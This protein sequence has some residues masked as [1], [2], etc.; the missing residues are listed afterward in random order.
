MSKPVL[1]FIVGPTASG[2]T[3][4]SID[5][6]RRMNAEI[7]S[8]DS[9]QV[10]RR[11]DIGSAKPTMEEMRGVVHHL[12]GVIEPT[13]RDFSVAKYREAAIDA[14]NDI[15]SRGKNAIVVGGTGLYVNSLMYPLEFNAPPDEAKRAYWMERESE[16]KGSALSHLRELDPARANALHPNDVK[17]II[18]AIEVSEAMGAPMSELGRGFTARD[19]DALPYEIK[20]AA[21]DMPREELYNRIDARVDAMLEAGFLGEVES[22]LESGITPELPAMQGLGYKQL[23]KYLLERGKPCAQ[24]Y[25]ET[26]ET[27]KR[28]TRRFAKR[29]LT[30]FRREDRIRW[31]S[32]AGEDAAIAAERIYGYFTE[33]RD[34][35]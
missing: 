4:V 15:H 1:Y 25:D 21:L 12:I 23:A 17:R 6:A 19:D 24:S 10:Y 32:M 22:L 7:I 28:E 27:I 11:L 30:W 31:I 33:V 9:I 34:G 13:E 26:V 16:Q 8:A 3:A 2:K 29:Q 35:E 20:A 5:V 18:R 14:I